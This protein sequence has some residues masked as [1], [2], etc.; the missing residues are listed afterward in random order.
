[1]AQT[2]WPK[3]W[4]L[5]FQFDQGYMWFLL[6]LSCQ[7]LMLKSTGT[8]LYWAAH[9]GTK[10]WHTYRQ[11][12]NIHRIWKQRPLLSPVPMDGRVGWTNTLFFYKNVIFRVQDQNFLKNPDFS[13]KNFL[14]LSFSQAQNFLNFSNF[15][16][17]ISTS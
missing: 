7:N 17:L 12:N 10:I 16:K 4:F 9:R 3:H 5:I 1:M 15:L 6:S 8:E 2:S 11:T 13:L 14:F